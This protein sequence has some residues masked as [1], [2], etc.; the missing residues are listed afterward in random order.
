MYD[1]TDAGVLTTASDVLF[2][3]GRDGYFY[4]LDARTGVKLWQTSFGSVSL[5]SSPMTY[6]VEGRQYVA[7]IGGHVLAAYGLRD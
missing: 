1:L 2:T 5:R 4:A 7:V 3:G 6:E